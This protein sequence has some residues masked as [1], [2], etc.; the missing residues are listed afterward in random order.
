MP[1][2]QL[3]YPDRTH[4]GLILLG[5]NHFR[6]RLIT[7]SGEIPQTGEGKASLEI[8]IWVSSSDQFQAE[9]ASNVKW[10]VL[11]VPAGLKSTCHL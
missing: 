11:R 1:S 3:P 10:F 2:R 5:Y 4:R 9:D 7:S 6:E 8:P